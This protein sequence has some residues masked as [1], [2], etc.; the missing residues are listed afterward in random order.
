[1]DAN[2]TDRKS[3]RQATLLVRGG[4][5][6]S[7]FAE[8]SEGLYM[9]SGYVYET[10]ETAERAFKGEDEHYIYSRYANPT[11]SMFEER[12]ALLEGAEVCRATASGMAAV[13]A[14]LLCQLKSGDRM[15]ASRAL[16]GSCH[17]I[18]T[19]LLPRYGIETELVDGTDLGQW[20]AALGRETACVFLETPSNPT[21][22]IIDLAPVAA[23]AHGAGARLVVDNVFATPVLQRPLEMGAD[24]VV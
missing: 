17:Y 3:W 4:L 12:L 9:T 5:R 10:A 6:R 1:M 13:F 15:V 16:F 22:E 7:P 2:A 21:L 19:E 24:I 11:V 14:A 18:I 23:L 8:T 20:E